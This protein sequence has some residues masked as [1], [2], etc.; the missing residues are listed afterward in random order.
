M[1]VWKT[2]MVLGIIGLLL[3]FNSRAEPIHESI[4]CHIDNIFFEANSE[5]LLGQVL[6][7]NSVTNRTEHPTRWGDTACETIYQPKQY[8]WTEYSA[9]QLHN[10]KD[11]ERV[12]YEAIHSNIGTILSYGEVPG[13]E[14]VNHYL[15]CDHKD[16]VSWWKDMDFLGQVGAHCFYRD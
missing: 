7:A 1:K 5:P 15:R 13:F 8:S 12:G 16:R 4:S 2:M 10:F 14:G 3:S 6:V 9:R 11:T